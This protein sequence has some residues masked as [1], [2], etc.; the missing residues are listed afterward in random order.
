VG[1]DDFDLA[2]MVKE[3][4]T[5]QRI[6]GVL[7]CDIALSGKG[8]SMA[9]IMGSLNGRTAT[10]MGAGQIDTGYL[11]LIGG[12][13]SSQILQLINPFAPRADTT[14]YNCLVSHFEIS[15][16]L[17]ENRALVFDTNETTV[18]GDGTID[19]KTEKL[20]LSIKPVPKGGV[21][22]KGV[23]QFDV[24]LSDLTNP[25]KLSGTLANPELA[26]D[27]TSSALTIGKYAGAALFGPIGIAAAMT[28]VSTGSEN[29]CVEAIAAAEEGV[30]VSKD[31]VVIGTAKA[32]A[33]V[34]RGVVEGT[35]K[36]L[37]GLIGD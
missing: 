30:K 2:A 7:N 33:G 4:G 11:N 8:R 3:L 13:L 5:K 17:A 6:E 24:S 18:V 32:A 1:V 14:E 36:F 20:N 10:V 28:T 35:A 25:F 37:K 9:E 22:I 21:G 31:G 34:V 12:G 26:I 27:P 15:D 29:P 23:A 16:G 19:L